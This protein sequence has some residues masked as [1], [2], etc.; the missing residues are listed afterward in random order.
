MRCG[1]G[2]RKCG[3]SGGGA[4]ASLACVRTP[5]QGCAQAC[6]KSVHN[7]SMMFF[8]LFA[9]HVT[10]MLMMEIQVELKP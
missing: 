10:C 5:S 2:G 3:A 6:R 4:C 9:S 8:E 1:R 7:P